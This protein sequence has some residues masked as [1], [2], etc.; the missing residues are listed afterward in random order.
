MYST[1]Y[2]QA[3]EQGAAT[4]FTVRREIDMFGRS[5]LEDARLEIRRLRKELMQVSIELTRLRDSVEHC[6]RP[7]ED[8]WRRYDCGYLTG[9]ILP[10]WMIHWGN[11]GNEGITI[12][13]AA[14]VSEATNIFA[15]LWIGKCDESSLRIEGEIDGVK[16]TEIIL[17]G[18]GRSIKEDE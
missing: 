12:I 8:S 11:P 5:K 4:A 13:R 3:N 2:R 10:I 7:P 6:A 17:R 18:E 1:A 14:S 16:P 9:T 15:R